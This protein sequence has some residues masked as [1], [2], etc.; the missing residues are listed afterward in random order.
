M[1]KRKAVELTKLESEI[2]KVVWDAEADSISVREILEGMNQ[3]RKKK[4]A[5]NTVQTVVTILKDKDVLKQ[6]PG[7]GRAHRFQAT[8]S[9]VDTGRHLVSDLAQR[10]FAGQ[11]QPLIHRLIDDAKLTPEELAQLRDF[12]ESKLED[13]QEDEEQSP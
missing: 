13:S 4:L 1:S 8:I 10:L 6:V 5:Y 3:A 12:V 2:M 9:R 11:V 7:S